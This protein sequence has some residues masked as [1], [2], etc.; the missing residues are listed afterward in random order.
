MRRYVPELVLAD[1]R[2]PAEVTVPDLL[3]HT[4]GL[5]W[6]LLVDT[7][8]GDDVLT[9][10]VAKLAELEVI[11]RPGARASDSRAGYSL[12]GRVI[13]KVVGNPYEKAIASLLLSRWGCRTASSRP[14]RL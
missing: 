11:A 7:G 10:F 14:K 1:K 13:E 6:H 5:G 12:F 3:N 9:G 8:K 4:S 2:A